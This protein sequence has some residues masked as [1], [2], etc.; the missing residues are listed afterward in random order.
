MALQDRMKWDHTNNEGLVGEP[1]EEIALA[2]VNL[3]G[4]QLSHD[5]ALVSKKAKFGVLRP[6][7]KTIGKQLVLR[8]DLAEEVEIVWND[9]MQHIQKESP[10]A[11]L[12]KFFCQR[13][14]TE[15]GWQHIVLGVEF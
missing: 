8:T 7:G 12:A 1:I 9:W 4:K 6:Q 13:R 11:A 10:A 15:P 14:D 3:A 2:L 5:A